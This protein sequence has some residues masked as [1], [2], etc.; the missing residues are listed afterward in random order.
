MRYNLWS[1]LPRPPVAGLIPTGRGKTGARF[2][3]FCLFFFAGDDYY[4]IPVFVSC[5]VVCPQ[6]RDGTLLR[7]GEVKAHH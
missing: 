3:F 1:K 4:D 2:S 7:E 5:G 6:L